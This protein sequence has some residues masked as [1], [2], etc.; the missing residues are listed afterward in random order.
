MKAMKTWMRRPALLLVATLLVVAFVAT[1]PFAHSGIS[2]AHA[3]TATPTITVSAHTVRPKQKIAVIGQGFAP[4]DTVTVF[5]DQLGF[6]F[7]N[8][9][10][11][12]NGNCSGLVTIPLTGPQGQHMILAQGSQ[13]GEAVANAP[14]ILNPTIFFAT[15][16]GNPNHGGPGTSTAITGYAFQLNETVSVYW[17]DATGTLLGTAT[18]DSSIGFF[19]FPFVTPTHVAPGKYKITVVRANQKPATLTTTFTVLPPAVTAAA[20]VRSGQLLKFHLSGFQGNENVDISWNANG[21]QQIGMIQTNFS[22]FFASPSFGEVFI[23]SAPLG[24]YTLTFTGE[25][26]GLQVSAPLSVGPGIQ[27]NVLN[28]PGGTI[29]VSGGGF[30]SGETLTVFIEGQKK[31]TSV[32]VTTAADGSFQ[33]N[34]IAPLILTP[35]PQYHIVAT[36]SDGSERATAFFYILAPSISWASADINDQNPTAAYGSLGTI[37]GQDFPA[38][39]QVT[40]YWNYQQAGQVT[41]GTVL[42]AADGSFSFDLTT[43][44]SPFTAN[45]TIEAIAATST[46]T[47][48]F[49]VQPQPAMLLNPT[50]ALVGHTVSISGGS[51]DGN[52]TVTITLA[53][54][55]SVVGTATTASDGTFTTSFTIPSNTEGGPS[56]VSASDGTVSSSANLVIQ[57]PL[58]ITPTTGSSGTSITVQSPNF[59]GNGND[60]RC[61]AYQP[62]IAWYDPTTGTSLYLSRACP[63]G[64]LNETVT[65]PAN[66][67]SGRTYEI[68]LI[69]G[70]YVIGQAPFTAQ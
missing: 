16:Q 14:I 56:S 4:N 15:S 9:T 12:G 70:G 64:P 35:G 21:G 1:F 55:G 53:A 46:F 2:R 60:F 45:A 13:P 50:S 40:L 61:F 57:V 17:G 68:E 36:N 6:P 34:L 25:S 30:R 51:F 10:C 39:E 11:D 24:S 62:Y 41:V 42:A 8:L 52:A 67:V 19:S 58:T 20:G 63:Q 65:A 66:L 26:S 59:S 32:S 22:G 5:L 18:S 47:A 28:N 54:S 3:A 33:A 27:L 31:A 43:P 49:Q 44:S 7:G 37:S 69:A 48:S 23:P 38:N 29:P